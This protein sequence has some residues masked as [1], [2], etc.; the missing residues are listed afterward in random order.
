MGV[1]DDNTNIKSEYPAQK[2]IR[3]Y[4][5]D[6]FADDK[7][8][9]YSISR[10]NPNSEHLGWLILTCMQAM[11]PLRGKLFYD[12][13]VDIHDVTVKCLG[14]YHYHIKVICNIYPTEI[15]WKDMSLDAVNIMKNACYQGKM[16][17]YSVMKGVDYVGIDVKHS[18]V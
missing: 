15:R 2:I 8:I 13:G 5:A 4:L 3:E 17:G 11:Y 10:L 14:Q 1:F 18:L 9:W 16:P 6:Y 12:Y 7:G